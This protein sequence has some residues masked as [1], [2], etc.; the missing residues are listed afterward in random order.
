MFASLPHILD[1][2]ALLLLVTSQVT[3]V[4]LAR[5]LGPTW[6]APIDGG[7]RL[8]D[9]H[10]VFGPHKTWRGL[11]GGTVT[12]AVA[13]SFLSVGLVLGAAFGFLALLGDL[14]SSFIKRRMGCSSGADMPF[15][16][17]LPE[18][19]LPMLSLHGA[20]QLD[21]QSIVGTTFIFFLLDLLLTRPL[22][23]V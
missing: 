5:A 15:L 1:P 9:E 16:D 11:I 19:L 4:V 8:S 2:T 18:A 23:A 12:A 6:A 7:R 20:L 21:L 3:P 17:Q 10:Y 22:G 13:G 14:I